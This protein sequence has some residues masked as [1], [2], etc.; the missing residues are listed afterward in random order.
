MLV[1]D[2]TF[3]SSGYTTS[4][5][6]TLEIM[7][8]VPSK[9]NMMSIQ[10]GYSVSSSSIKN[11]TGG[12]VSAYSFNGS[13]WSTS[14]TIS[15]KTG[16]WVNSGTSDAIWL[17]GTSSVTNDIKGK[18][19]QLEYYKGLSTNT[20]HLVGVQHAFKWSELMRGNVT[21]AGCSTG[22]TKVFYYNTGDDSWNSVDKIPSNSAVWLKHFCN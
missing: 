20:W 7:Q 22:Y 9:W 10:N 3:A 11:N 21:P 18:K 8:T 5:L 1:V 6:E 4:D 17:K 19:E 14:A 15:P 12:A 2:K 16:L 13:S